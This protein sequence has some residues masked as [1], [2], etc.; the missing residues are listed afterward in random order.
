MTPLSR[1]LDER[2]WPAFAVDLRSLALFRFGLG[3][4]VC[5]DALGRL[6]DVGA[7]YGDHGVLPL[8][9]LSE[10]GDAW[11]WSLHRAMDGTG[12]SSLLI[13]LQALAGLALAAG[14]RTRRAT[15]LAW[16]LA[17]SLCNRNPLVLGA[18]DVLLCALLFWGLFLPLAG[19]WSIDATLTESPTPEARHLSWASAALTVQVL[20]VFFFNALHRSGPEWT[21]QASAWQQLM[22]LDGISRGLSPWLAV[23]PGLS[24]AITHWSQWLQ[25]LGPPLFLLPT[26]G[27]ARRRV[28]VSGV[29]RAIVLLQLLLLVALTLAT[30]AMGS[31]GWLLLVGLAALVSGRFWDFLWRRRQRPAQARLRVFFDEHCAICRTASRM[32]VGLLL[33][34]AELAPARSNRRADSLARANDSW[35]VLDHDDSA[36]LRGA[37]LLLLLRRSPLL[38][39]LGPAL[40]KPVLR[41]AAD[42]RYRQLAPHRQRLARGSAWLLPRP[43]ASLVPAVS[44]S[45][46]IGVILLLVLVGNAL[47]LAS[48]GNGLARLIAPPLQLLRLDQR[49]DAFAPSPPRQESRWTAPGR[50]IGAGDVNALPRDPAAD[51]I[52]WR[53]Y[54]ERVGRATSNQA[55]LLSAWT[56]RLCREYN[57]GRAAG[58]PER[59][60]EFRLVQLLRIAGRHNDEQTEQ[61]VLWRQDC[62]TR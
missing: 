5:F 39:W 15:L 17:V 34:D 33:V 46:W 25:L 9:L 19:R 60:A 8:G 6:G 13:L 49:W 22:M 53:F 51:E 30:L 16:V 40:D 11:R 56:Q 12:F 35:V 3:L 37:A 20:A 21:Q 55:A 32:A 54:E 27:A 44:A 57:A 31:I 42:H 7:F 36:H 26:I 47:T 38:G 59:L 62:A 52:R 48:P 10:S 23:E 14:F 45:R 24:A 61:R 18:G 29:L 50:T 2:V 58:S 28:G 1:L 43:T 4:L 41:E